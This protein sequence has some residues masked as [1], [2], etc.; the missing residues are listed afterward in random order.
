MKKENNAIVVTSIIAGVV[1]LIAVSAMFMFSGFSTSNDVVTVTGLSTI[2]ATPDLVGVYFT[3]ETKGTTSAEASDANTV[4]LNSLQNSLVAQ[5]FTEEDLKTESFSIQPNINWVNGKQIQDGY[6]AYHYL[7]LEFSTEDLDK[8][9]P[10]IDAG[11]DSGAGISYINFELTQ[12]AQNSYKAQ[13]LELAA[14]DA[15]IKADA[16][17]S[18]FGKE[19]GKLVS[20]SVSEFGYYPWNV[21]SSSGSAEDSSAIKTA[22]MSISPSEEEITASVSATFKLQ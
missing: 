9:S 16:V 6:I 7:K 3:I 15:Q 18:G 8:L 17:A 11:V 22:T 5:G 2:K 13:A 4:I 12:E 10:V 1:L 14:Q 21:Y 19:A 20:V